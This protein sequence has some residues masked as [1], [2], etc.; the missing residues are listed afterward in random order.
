MKVNRDILRR[1]ITGEL[2]SAF[3]AREDGFFVG[4]VRGNC[5][6]LGLLSLLGALL[7]AAVLFSLREMPVM[8]DLLMRWFTLV[9]VIGLG[10]FGLF[11]LR[12]A[13]GN[14]PVP[15]LWACQVVFAVYYMV[16]DL[17]ILFL[18]NQMQPDIVRMAP[19]LLLM[20][21]MTMTGGLS[22]ACFG[23]YLL[24]IFLLASEPALLVY[25]LTAVIAAYYL[26]RE[27]YGRQ[28]SQFIHDAQAAQAAQDNQE[29]LRRLERM[30]SWDEQIQMNNRRAM[31]AWME[32]VWPLCVRN[33]I[34][35]AVI[36]VS[37]DGMEKMRKEKGP[38]AATARLNQFAAALKPFVRR[39]SDFLGRYEEDKFIILYSGPSLKD[40]DMLVK[41][42]RDDLH[43]QA[44]ADAE[45]GFLSL[46]MGIIYGLPRDNTVA[47]QWMT[48][49]DDVLEKVKMQGPGAMAIE[50]A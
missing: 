37:P 43:K 30:T 32:A 27:R 15:A 13:K 17:C 1:F 36:V 3:H 48:R 40:T 28:V 45:G 31:S 39:Q 34:P 5:F 10:V 25:G 9:A 4:L 18:T 35:V 12:Q 11:F 23:G 49:A 44:W 29:L 24:G 20:A 8:R 7:Q 16:V 19:A 2:P 6:R 21:M 26:S 50:E 22:I 41:R 38:G 33:R 14:M 42:I 47:A 46:S